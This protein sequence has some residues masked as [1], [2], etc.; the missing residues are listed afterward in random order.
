MTTKPIPDSAAVPKPKPV[1]SPTKLVAPKPA[2]Q[3]GLA[4]FWA[5]F[6]QPS[7]LAFGVLAS[8]FAASLALCVWFFSES[9]LAGPMG[10]YLPRSPLDA[11]G[12]ATTE[13]LR[14]GH[15]P[16]S[17]PRLFVL[18]TSTVGQ[19]IGSGKAVHDM[20]QEQSGQDW[21]VILL[22]TPLQSP[23]DTFALL[24]RALQSQTA[25]SPPAMVVLG[26]GILRLRWNVAQML[27]FAAMPRLGLRSDWHDAEVVIN[28]GTPV[29]RH[30]VYLWDNLSFVLIN[31]SE[32]L[33]RLAMLHPAK[34]VVDQYA[35]QGLTPQ[36]R[37]KIRDA[38][39]QEIR[40]AID[41]EMPLYLA[42]LARLK[43]LLDS[44]PNT[45]LILIEEPL[46]PGLIDT[47]HLQWVQVTFDTRL[48]AF[49]AD[50]AV[51]YWPMRSEAALGDNDYF[52]DLHIKPGPAQIRAQTA[53]VGHIIQDI[54]SGGQ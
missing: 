9:T 1:K 20:I 49:L 51:P 42:Q 4:A 35:R 39:G 45:R 28:G 30:G 31:G 14:A 32:S 44:R 2:W 29:P 16:P 12:F 19:A 24:D 41:T 46:S 33:L 11:E 8:A 21:E 13:A 10:A 50:H 7:A 26:S 25:D 15:T 43:T 17:R 38:I 18:G 37:S 53:L 27:E 47:Q 3:Q 40:T 5:G 48:A 6:S 34:R 54:A 36:T 22:T 52:D 23:L